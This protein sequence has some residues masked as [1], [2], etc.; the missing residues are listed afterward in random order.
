MGHHLPA[1]ATE[2]SIYCGNLFLQAPGASAGPHP[3]GQIRVSLQIYG[4]K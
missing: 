4:T 2:A 1:E 3:D